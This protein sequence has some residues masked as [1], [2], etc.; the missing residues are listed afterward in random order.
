MNFRIF[1]TGVSD[2][3]IEVVSSF[4]LTNITYNKEFNDLLGFTKDD[5]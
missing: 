1:I 3:A 5:V 4:R 2:I